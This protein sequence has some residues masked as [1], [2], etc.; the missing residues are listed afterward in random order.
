MNA[1]IEVLLIAGI[2][3]GVGLLVGV[4]VLLRRTSGTGNDRVESRLAAMAEAQE[5]TD[6]IVREEFAR[7]RDEA[8]KQSAQ[9]REETSTSI[10]RTA[11]TLIKSVG[12]ISSVQK[13]QLESFAVRL[14]DLSASNEKRLEALRATVDDRLRL[15]QEDNAKRLD[16]MRVTVDEK[17]QGT[18]EKRLGESFKQVS[19]RLEQVHRGLGEMQTLAAGV[20]DLKKVLTNVKTRG[21]LAEM[22]LGTLLEQFLSPDQFATNVETRRGSNQRVEFA[23][24]LPGRDGDARSIVWLPIDAK[25]P[26]ED[27]QRLVEAQERGDAEGVESAAKQLENCVKGAAKDIRDKYLDPPATTDFGVM[28]LGTEGLYSEVLRRT[29]LFE[30]LQ[31]DYRVTVAGPTTIAAL[32]NSLQMGF[33]TLAIEKRASE[34]W[35]ILGAVKS[36]FG[37]FGDLL[38]GVGKKLSEAQNKIEDAARKTRTIERKLQGVQEL[39]AAAG[40]PPMLPLEA[41]TDD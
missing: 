28:F 37:K 15:L 10:A 16:L 24:K 34:V 33:R 40:E 23:V 12:E 6:R 25:F 2:A 7:N 20:G 38:D 36:E 5:R 4:V 27:Y 29:G 32:L 9:T 30:S 21:T 18:L 13:S 14:G 8:S 26:I 17:L 39:P 31:R 19:D 22:Q 1:M 35:A 11:E 41:V 3:L